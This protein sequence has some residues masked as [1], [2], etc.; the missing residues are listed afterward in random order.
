[1]GETT[2][3]AGGLLVD[4]TGA[5]PRRADVLV[6]DGRVAE[7]REPGPSGGETIRV[8]GMVVC[9]GFIDLHSHTDFSLS[10][11]PAADTA[12]H[13]GVTTLLGG[14]CGFSPFPV[15]DRSALAATAG[16]LGAGLDYS[17]SDLDGY[18]AMVEADPPAVNLATQ[19]GHQALRI[20][21]IGTDRRPAGSG[22]LSRMRGLLAEAA[23]QGAFGFSTGLIYAPGSFADPAEVTELAAEAARHGMLY[24]THMRDERSGLLD[25]V[26][27]AL[28]TARA[29]GVRLEISH[30]KA[31]ERPNHGLVRAALAEIEA[32]R[33]EGVDVTADV[34]PYSASSTTLTSRLPG[35]AMDGGVPRLLERLADRATRARIAAELA[36]R[37]WP[38]DVVIAELPPG[39]FDRFV[40]HS[41]AELGG[42]PADATLEL[43]EAHHG[44]V[45]VINHAMAPEDVA[46]VLA[47]PLVSVAS[48]GWTLRPTGPG[49]PHPRSFGTFVR[50]LGR[51]V[52]EQRLIGLAEAVR[53]MTSLPAARLGLADRG[54]VRPG[55]VADLAVFDPD[56]VIDNADFTDPWR[57][58]TGVRHVLVRGV[59][60]L[61]DGAATG[62]RPGRVL[63]RGA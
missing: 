47:H 53:K 29:S 5:P 22:E 44:K 30:L 9:P 8:D 31:M 18:A 21:A 57:L 49:R 52:R 16:F 2:T 28:D 34:Y 23:E 33:A 63:R 55:S 39:P 41:L 3:L 12:V 17:W 19:V 46:T 1:M 27:E 40:G 58:A 10:D 61:R 25:A 38:A 35:W 6:R 14:N 32:A 36:E 43:L 4:G 11:H 59:A 7:V 15:V 20:A 50:V 42:D 60:V 37:L 54:E 51:Y 45:A 24:S 56:T 13:Q 26:R 62:A 48:D